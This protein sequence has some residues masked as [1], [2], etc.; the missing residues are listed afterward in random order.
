M[1]DPTT[2]GLKAPPAEIEGMVRNLCAYALG[3]PDPIKRYEDLTHQQVLFEGMVE[4]IRRERGKLVADLVV[5]GMSV[6]DL[7]AQTSLA[8][9]VNVRRLVCDADQ[10][11][12]VND[13]IAARKEANR[14]AAESAAAEVQQEARPQPATLPPHLTAPNGKRLLSAADRTALGLSVESNA[15]LGV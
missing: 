9:V 3:E 11:E 10:T 15:Q 12:R 5:T 1:Y 2:E 13:A 14:Q 6:T 4:A 8:K 7:A